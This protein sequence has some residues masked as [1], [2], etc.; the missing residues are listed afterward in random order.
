MPASFTTPEDTNLVLSGL[1]VSDV[2]SSS[3]NVTVT[4]SVDSGA[5]LMGS[6]IIVVTSGSGTNTVTI[7]GTVTAVNAF[8]AN[9]GVQ[10]EFWPAGNAN[11]PVTL[12]MTTSDNGNTGSGGT[13]IDTD[14]RTISVTPVNDSPYVAT[15]ID[16]HAPSDV[17]S[18]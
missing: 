4:L 11:G 6:S 8:L 2:D 9:P 1:S 5:I 3:G 15:E 14:T 17:H 13:L 16:P 12:T 10:P 18:S 7:T